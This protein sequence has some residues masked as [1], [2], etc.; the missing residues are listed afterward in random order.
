MKTQGL[1]LPVVAAGVLAYAVISIAK[2]QPQR[3]ITNPPGAPPRTEFKDTVAAVGLVE[4]SSEI[5]SIG[6][7]RTGVVDEVYVKLGD[8]VQK[9]TPLLKLRTSELKAQ[10]A[11]AEASLKEAEARVSVAE[12]QVAA[13]EAQVHV[14]EAELAQ[15]KR[16]LAFADNVKDARVISDEERTQRALTVATHEAK[17]ES[18]RATVAS[19]QANVASAKAG[20]ESARASLNVVDVELDRCIVKAPGDATVLQIKIRPGEYVSSATNTSA[21]LT[22][23]RIDPLHVRADI[24]EHEAWRVRPSA[25]AEALVR[26]NPEQK[27]RLT[28]VR[29]EPLVIPKRSLT[30]D[31]TE[32]VDTR[33]LQVVYRVENKSDVPL[34]VGQQMDVFIE[35][36]RDVV[37]V[38]QNGAKSPSEAATLTTAK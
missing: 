19:S 18:A 23:G 27:V 38:S 22:L 17:L 31:V 14:T 37:A 5:I 25:A 10:R 26:G 8:T 33:V 12:S 13:S 16:M 21:W 9:D 32:R 3:D 7:V 24:D 29:F 2:T 36:A 15:S 20:V 30:G 35:A 28:F 6:S 4:P 11:V 1:I 34:F